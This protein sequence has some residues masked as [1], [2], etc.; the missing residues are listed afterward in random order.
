MAKLKSKNPKI[1]ESLVGLTPGVNFT[2]IF[3]AAFL[4]ESRMCSISVLKVGAKAVH[5]MLVKLT[6]G[7]I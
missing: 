2:N 6:T 7:R 3:G 4:H 1:K 5:I